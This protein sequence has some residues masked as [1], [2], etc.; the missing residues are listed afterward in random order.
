MNT[1]FAISSARRLAQVRIA[2]CLQLIFGN[3]DRIQCNE[4]FFLNIPFSAAHGAGNRTIVRNSLRGGVVNR[5]G[6]VPHD[7]RKVALPGRVDFLKVT[8]VNN[9]F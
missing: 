9:L 3:F 2:N 7:V 4:Y 5:V 1:L 6:E 8:L